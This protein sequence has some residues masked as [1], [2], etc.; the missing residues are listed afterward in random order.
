MTKTAQDYVNEINIQKAKPL[1]EQL[2]DLKIAGAKLL[3]SLDKL[4]KE[5]DTHP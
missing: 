1:D 4:I 5:N 2:N 3:V